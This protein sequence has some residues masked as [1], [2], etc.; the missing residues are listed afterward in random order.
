MNQPRQ[1]SEMVLVE[2]MAFVVVIGE[3]ESPHEYQGQ[4]I[5]R[6]LYTVGPR[7]QQEEAMVVVTTIPIEAEME[8]RVEIQEYPM[9]LYSQQHVFVF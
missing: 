8:I 7:L 5:L 3:E 1:I 9:T 4:V 6:I 2:V